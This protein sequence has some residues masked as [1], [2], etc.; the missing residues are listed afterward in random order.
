M[1]V[2]SFAHGNFGWKLG[3]PPLA[4]RKNYIL[5]KCEKK[6]FEIVIQKKSKEIVAKMNSV[7]LTLIYYK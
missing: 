1:L 3:Y 6:S 5:I 7:L 4:K 2:A